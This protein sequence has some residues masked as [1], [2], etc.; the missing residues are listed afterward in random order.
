MDF[1]QEI[2]GIFNIVYTITVLIYHGRA[3]LN[4][5]NWGIGNPE[6]LYK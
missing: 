4:I 2:E 1:T 5:S 6:F 3:S